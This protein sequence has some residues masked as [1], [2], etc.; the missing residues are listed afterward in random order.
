[1]EVSG[2][3]NLVLCIALSSSSIF[4]S[5]NDTG[6]KG[7]HRMCISRNPIQQAQK[8]HLSLTQALVC[9]TFEFL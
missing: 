6:L 3:L 9:L 7:G 4:C 8:K 5:E 2:Y 1:M